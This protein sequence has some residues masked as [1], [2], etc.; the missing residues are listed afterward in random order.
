MQ[1]CCAIEESNIILCDGE[2]RNNRGTVC[3]MHV[4]CVDS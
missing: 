4:Q 3:K 2:L 1:K